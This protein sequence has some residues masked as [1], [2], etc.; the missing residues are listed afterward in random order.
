MYI[1]REV[2]RYKAYL[3]IYIYI[4][5]CLYIWEEHY[6]QTGLDQYFMQKSCDKW[7]MVVSLF[8]RIQISII[9]NVCCEKRALILIQFSYTDF[10]LT[11]LHSHTL[12]LFWQLCHYQWP[13][14]FFFF[15]LKH[16]FHLLLFCFASFS[17]NIILVMKVGVNVFDSSPGW[18]PTESEWSQ[19]GMFSTQVCT[20][21]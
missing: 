21:C 16:N 13:H 4:C 12:C 17:R 1:Y 7:R 20:V 15:S 5:V 6:F 2:D 3:S 11:L 10:V 8:T 14:V 19:D 18:S 9:F